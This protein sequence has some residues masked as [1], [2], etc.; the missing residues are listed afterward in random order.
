MDISKVPPA[1]VPT[2]QPVEPKGGNDHD[3]DDSAG[4]ATRPTPPTG[5]GSRV[6]TTA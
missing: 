4:A 5:Q 2:P 6:D 1:S 3:R